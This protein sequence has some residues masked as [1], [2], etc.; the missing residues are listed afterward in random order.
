MAG[1]EPTVYAVSSV[2]LDREMIVLEEP[3]PLGM[4]LDVPMDTFGP[5]VGGHRE[6]IP[7]QSTDGRTVR[8]LPVTLDES[9]LS[10]PRL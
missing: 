9:A 5:V 10:A 2:D 4:Q 1:S 8:V 6:R 3:G 7:G